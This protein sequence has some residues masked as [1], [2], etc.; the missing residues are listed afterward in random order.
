[1]NTSLNFDADWRTQD[2][3][4]REAQVALK[5]AISNLDPGAITSVFEHLHKEQK[6]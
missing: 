2:A 6:A 5:A 3:A 4:L 1:M